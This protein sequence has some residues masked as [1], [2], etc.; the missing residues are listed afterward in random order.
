[1]GQIKAQYMAIG[2]AKFP[3]NDVASY[4][5]KEEAVDVYEWFVYASNVWHLRARGS[6]DLLKMYE[7]ILENIK[8]E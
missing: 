3:K 2:I 5:P 6:Q 4:C 7:Q 1:M 8:S